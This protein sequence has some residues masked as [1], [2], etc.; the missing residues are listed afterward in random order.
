M[1]RFIGARY[2][3]PRPQYDV[4]IRRDVDFTGID[5]VTSQAMIDHAVTFSREY[6]HVWDNVSAYGTAQEI[7]SRNTNLPRTIGATTYAQ[8]T[9]ISGDRLPFSLVVNRGP[10]HDSAGVEAKYVNDIGLGYHPPNGNAT[11]I[12]AILVHEFAHLLS[13]Q[14][15]MRGKHNWLAALK[16]VF[17]ADT[18]IPLDFTNS[19]TLDWISKHI[20]AYAAKDIWEFVAECE[21]MA[22]FSPSPH[23]VSIEISLFLRERAR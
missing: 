21:S 12:D 22:T 23:P 14:G 17:L 15:Y 2:L 10:F 19:V 3:N 6:P 7:Y 9:Y 16:E 5:R 1:P 4:P 18:G 20:S 8:T 11:A 13:Y